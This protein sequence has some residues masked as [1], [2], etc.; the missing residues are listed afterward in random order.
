VI[1]DSSALVAIIRGE[2]DFDIYV[3]ALE[4][5][6]LNKIA[7]PTYLEL[8]MVTVGGRSQ[9]A[10][11]IVDEIMQR[12]R[13]SIIDFTAEMAEVALDAFLKYGKG[14]GHRAQL[15]FGDCISFATA[16]VEAMPLLFKGDDFRHTDI[17]CVA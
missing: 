15:N 5:S 8:C 10:K 2:S 4:K 7:A 12:F 14:C 6:A 11:L 16:R 3:D 1:V 17:E 13:I 9:E